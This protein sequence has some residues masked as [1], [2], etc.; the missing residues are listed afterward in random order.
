MRLENQSIP[1]PLNQSFFAIPKTALIPLHLSSGLI[2]FVRCLFLLQTPIYF[3]LHV[4]FVL[5]FVDYLPESAIHALWHMKQLM[6]QFQQ[7]RFLYSYLGA[8]HEIHPAP[9]LYD[10]FLALLLGHSLLGH[11]FIVGVQPVSF[12][13][14]GTHGVLQRIKGTAKLALRR[15]EV[16]LP[17]LYHVEGHRISLNQGV[18][19]LEGHE[20]FRLSAE[21]S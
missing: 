3:P 18:L 12:I 4:I 2:M 17:A 9:T 11:S 15:K 13:E 6:D 10:N 19:R 21:L 5:H 7:P 1:L 8:L 14:H 20:G 16:H